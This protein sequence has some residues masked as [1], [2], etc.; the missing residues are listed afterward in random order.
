M[1]KLKLDKLTSN[2]FE[3]KELSKIKGGAFICACK[4]YH[5]CGCSMDNDAS[6]TAASNEFARYNVVYL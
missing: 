6:D 3:V 2:R 4:P 5:L 1:K